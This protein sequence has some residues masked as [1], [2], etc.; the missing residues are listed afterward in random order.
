MSGHISGDECLSVQT[1]ASEDPGRDIERR[2]LRNAL[3]LL[4]QITERARDEIKDAKA[5]ATYAAEINN[6]GAL[7]AQESRVEAWAGVLRIIREA[8]GVGDEG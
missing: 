3:E 8:T 6:G 4:G 5:G 2:A 7:M 1:A